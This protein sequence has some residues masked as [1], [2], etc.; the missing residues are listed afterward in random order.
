MSIDSNYMVAYQSGAGTLLQAH[1]EVF[2]QSHLGS[3]I[4]PLVMADPAMSIVC[5]N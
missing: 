4:M 3:K 1:R 2:E 5:L